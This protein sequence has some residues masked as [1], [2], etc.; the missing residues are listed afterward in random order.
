VRTIVG[1]ANG[2]D[3]TSRREQERIDLRHQQL[4]RKRQRRGG[5]AL[6]KRARRVVE[7]GRALLKE[8]KGLG[9]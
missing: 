4:T 5:D 7:D 3:R 1:K 9:R 2:S 6:P 8:A